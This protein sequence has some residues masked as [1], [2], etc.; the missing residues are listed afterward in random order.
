LQSILAA[1]ARVT[2]RNRTI[3]VHLL[4]LALLM[5]QWGMLAHA[6]THLN[7]DPHAAPT[8]T[9]VCGECLSFAPLLTAVGNAPAVVLSV[10]HATHRVL[11]AEAAAVVPPRAFDAFRSRA[12]PV[13]L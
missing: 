5:A 4:S 12:P 13:S 6:S 7:A 11:D 2:R 10:Q 8:K 1:E 9:Q 3:W